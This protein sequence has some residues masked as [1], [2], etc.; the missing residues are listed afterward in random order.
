MKLL[1]LILPVFLLLAACSSNPSDHDFVPP[2]ES[3]PGAHDVPQEVI[4]QLWKRIVEGQLQPNANPYEYIN[5]LG[6]G[7]WATNL[8]HEEKYDSYFFYLDRRRMLQIRCHPD[9]LSL[10]SEEAHAIRRG[11]AL[12]SSDAWI[13]DPI[14]IGATLR[15]DWNK[16]LVHRIY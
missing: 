13:K 6:L 3:A 15:Q 4:A 5:S 11:E 9:S 8:S 2:T 1:P 16:V 10:T 7:A 12:S 14:V